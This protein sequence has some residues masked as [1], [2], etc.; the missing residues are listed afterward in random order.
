MSCSTSALEKCE[1][2]T[3]KNEEEAEK[4][5]KLLAKRMKNAKEKC[6]GQIAKRCRLS[7]LRSSTYQYESNK[8]KSFYE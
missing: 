7:M 2:H 6:Q 3:K 4:C 8:N 1:Q 5:A